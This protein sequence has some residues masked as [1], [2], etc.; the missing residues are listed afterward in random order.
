M[1]DNTILATEVMRRW[2]QFIDKL[3]DML[4]KNP[5]LEDML[6]KTP[7]EDPAMHGR[8][9]TMRL[10]GRLTP[11]WTMNGGGSDSPRG[12]RLPI[13]ANCAAAPP[14]SAQVSCEV[15]VVPASFEEVTATFPCAR[16]LFRSR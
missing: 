9:R 11:S 6:S 4:S 14:V 5:Q 16:R 10:R 8:A 7:N 13:T 15:G 1:D 2:N 12:S 3:E